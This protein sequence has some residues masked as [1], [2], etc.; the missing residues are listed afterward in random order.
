M[1]E[2]YP[3]I[4]PEYPRIVPEFSANELINNLFRSAIASSIAEAGDKAG[5]IQNDEYYR[6][7]VDGVMAR[8]G[9][10]A[11]LAKVEELA[12]N[13]PDKY[14]ANTPREKT[15]LKYV[16]RADFRSFSH[17]SVLSPLLAVSPG[18][19]ERTCY[20]GTDKLGHMVQQGYDYWVIYNVVEERN[21]GMGL[22]YARAWGTWTEGDVV[23]PNEIR[24]YLL[25]NGMVS[26]AETIESVGQDIE[27][28]LTGYDWIQFMNPVPEFAKKNFFLRKLAH[29]IGV[30]D[31]GI[32]GTASSGIYSYADLEANAAGLQFYLD[33]EKDPE[34]LA[35]N[36]DIANYATCNWDEEVLKPRYTP[37]IAKRIEEA[38]NGKNVVKYAP[39]IGIS[40]DL[41]NNLLGIST[42][43]LFFSLGDN[44]FRT[45]FGAVLKLDADG[46]EFRKAGQLFLAADYLVRLY[47]LHYIFL[48]VQ[49]GMN[50]GA[51][52]FPVIGAGYELFLLGRTS[53]HAG[54]FFDPVGLDPSFGLGLLW[55][56]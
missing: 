39:G 31:K 40:Y 42:P 37:L 32:L 34:S 52:V 38:V 15:P 55:M 9:E 25:S 20:I 28:F 14:V 46:V 27:N 53:L 54:G 36:F 17:P 23:T 48:T 16:T 51:E 18:K 50:A 22:L 11:V 24:E 33:L 6:C 1:A 4:L 56:F 19:E 45:R 13:F 41:P 49:T 5:G 2:T 35:Q 30:H 21:P 47:N 8:I 7:V 12:R 26:D 44:E 29:L 10:G 3:Q 43:V